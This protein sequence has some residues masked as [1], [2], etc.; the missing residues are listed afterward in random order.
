MSQQLKLKEAPK[1][2]FWLCG[3]VIALLTLGL[4]M[5]YSSSSAY[6]AKSFGDPEFFI[7]RQLMWC[8]LGLGAIAFVLRVPTHIFSRRAGWFALFAVVCL[9]TVYTCVG[10][11][12]Y[13]PISY[14]N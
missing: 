6:A 2:D 5:V 11:H 14:W 9:H 1:I 4:V 8:A 7:R 12:S 10:V 3:S 13:T